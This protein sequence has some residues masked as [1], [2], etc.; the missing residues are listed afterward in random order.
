MF[1][2]SSQEYEYFDLFAPFVPIKRE[3][4]LEIARKFGDEIC[5]FTE[6]IDMNKIANLPREEYHT[7]LKELSVVKKKMEER[8]AALKHVFDENDPIPPYE[9]MTPL[10]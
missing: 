9:M 1:P 8:L 7:F 2:F 10:N 4:M 5:A 3:Q 6:F